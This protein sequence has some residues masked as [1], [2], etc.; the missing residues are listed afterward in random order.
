MLNKLSFSKLFKKQEMANNEIFERLN[1]EHEADK[2]LL[3]QNK[4]IEDSLLAQYRLH[5]LNA[6]HYAKE[7]FK[8]HLDFTDNSIQLLEK[9]MENLSLS[10]KKNNP[11]E[12][13]IETVTRLFAGYF[14]EVLRNKWG[15]K[16][17]R[18]NE[19][20]LKENGVS[21]K[22]NDK[23]YFIVSKIYRRITNGKE[24]NVCFYFDVINKDQNSSL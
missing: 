14:G 22:I 16:Y 19:N 9:I 15:G 20:P 24:D 11:N 4:N 10:L 13:Q 7:N 18:E 1:K 17:I 8:V 12:E 6:V 3:Q 5:A 21:I 2:L 23:Y